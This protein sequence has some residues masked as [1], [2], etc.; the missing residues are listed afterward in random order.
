MPKPPE[1]EA[2]IKII[3]LLHLICTDQTGKFRIEYKSGNNYLMILHD[4]DANATLGELIPNRVSA[5]LQQAFMK[6]F[7]QIL[8]KKYVLTIIRLDNKVSKEYLALLEKQG[9]K[10]QLVL[11]Y[12]H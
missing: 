8:L 7:N 10:V 11:P 12:N 5:T 9:L 3:E 1:H 4:Y 6:L 2:C